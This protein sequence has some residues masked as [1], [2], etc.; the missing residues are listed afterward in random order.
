LLG[1]GVNALLFFHIYFVWIDS[2]LFFGTRLASLSGAFGNRVKVANDLLR[3]LLSGSNV[4]R[5]HFGLFLL[6]LYVW[7]FRLWGRFLLKARCSDKAML[8]SAVAVENALLALS[9]L[10]KVRLFERLIGLSS[11]ELCVVVNFGRSPSVLRS[12]ACVKLLIRLHLLALGK[13]I[14]LEA[15]LVLLPVSRYLDHV[16]LLEVLAPSIAGLVVPLVG[17][18]R[19]SQQVFPIASPL[20]P[21]PTCPARLL[22][23]V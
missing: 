20:H 5:L 7:G 21:K 1:A 2:D 9:E 12:W 23:L 18:S 3:L 6:R 10:G 16:Q 4:S 14:R 13:L 22:V 19:H 8:A 11:R 17:H 15:E